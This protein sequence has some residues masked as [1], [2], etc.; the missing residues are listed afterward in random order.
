MIAALGIGTMAAVPE[1]GVVAALCR[2]DAGGA[3]L[4][5]LVLPIVIIPLV[6]GWL[7]LWGESVEIID[8]EFGTALR[9]LAELGLL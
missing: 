6:L 7:R 9:T 3:L 1:H 2:N 5:K 4:R 8:A